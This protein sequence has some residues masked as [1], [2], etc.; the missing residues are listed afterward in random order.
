MV[1]RPWRFACFLAATFLAIVLLRERSWSTTTSRWTESAFASD[2]ADQEIDLDDIEQLDGL[3]ATE[4]T[5]HFPDLYAEVDRAVNYWKDQ[6][7][8]ITPETVNVSWQQDGALRFL[9]HGNELRILEDR[10]S[11]DN[12]RYHERTVGQMSLIQRAIDSATAGGEMLPTIEAS[13]AFMDKVQP[14]SKLDNHSLWMVGRLKIEPRHDRLWL[15]PNFDFWYDRGFGTY[16]EARRRAMSYDAPFSDKIQKLVWRG[17]EW[18]QHDVRGS[19]LKVAE[20]KPWADVLRT[21]LDDTA[22]KKR[23]KMKP[24]EMC[25]YAAL[26]HTEGISYSGRLEFILLCNSLPVVH[27]LNWIVWYSHLLQPDGPRQ[28]YIPVHRN[29]SNLET[30]MTHYLE[31]PDEAETIIANSLNTFRNKYLTRAAQSCYIRRL[32]QGYSQVSFEPDPYRSSKEGG[33]T[34]ALRGR[35]FEKY[36]NAPKTGDYEDDDVWI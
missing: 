10:Q 24:A 21:D 32:I 2:G 5:A 26:A 3:T 14:Y 12:W 34:T 28:N 36:L 18:V 17:S 7:H 13:I 9:I 29:F 23:R 11:S 16:R 1:L 31:H 20:K 30:Q 6:D 33:S 15:M 22:E 25:K 4:C 35:S 8:L 19:L 27:D